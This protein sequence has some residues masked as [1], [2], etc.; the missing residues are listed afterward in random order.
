M[1]QLGVR[2]SASVHRHFL[3]ILV[4]ACVLLGGCGDFT[5]TKTPSLGSNSLLRLPPIGFN[6]VYG[7]N[8]LA[9]RDAMSLERELFA[10]G[11][12][13][14]VYLGP[15]PVQSGFV[16]LSDQ[17][18]VQAARLGVS[19]LIVTVATENINTIDGL[20]AFPGDPGPAKYAEKLLQNVQAIGYGNISSAQVHI[21]FS[22]R[23]EY[24]NLTWNKSSGYSFA[25]LIKWEAPPRGTAPLPSPTLRPTSTIAP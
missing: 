25:V 2:F 3:L 4:A 19:S 20:L 1:S 10:E 18:A 23:Y 5:I 11:A 24:A 13:W 17:R 9:S 15:E 14:E 16:K 7:P 21:Y 22:E 12:F 8:P 6:H